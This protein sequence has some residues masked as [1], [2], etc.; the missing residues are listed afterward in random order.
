MIQ[1]TVINPQSA[2]AGHPMTARF[3]AAAGTIGRATTN[4]LVLDDPGRT[5]SRLHA[6]VLYRDGCYFIIDRGG[7]PLLINDQMLGAGN[8]AP[9]NDGDR[10]MIG[11][12]ELT[13]QALPDTAPPPVADRPTQ[14]VTPVGGDPPAHEDP[15][16]DLMA[17][18][19]PAPATPT[20]PAMPMSTPAPE[21]MPSD[22]FA[23]PL[24]PPPSAAP[25]VAPPTKGRGALDDFSDLTTP[26]GEDTPN[27]DSLFGGGLSSGAGGDPLANSPLA[28]PLYRPNTA[29]A[30]DP[31]AALV[32]GAAPPTPAPRSDH[33]PIE[34]F[35]YRPPQA[36]EQTPAATSAPA[37]TPAAAAVPAAPPVAALKPVAPATPP[38]SQPAPRA[39]DDVLLAALLRGLR[40]DTLQPPKALT[41]ELMER[42]GVLLRDAVDGTLQLLL[43]RQEI[44]RELRAEMTMITPQANNPLKFSPDVEVAL[45]HLLGPSVRGFMPADEAMRDAFDDLR[46]HQFGVMVGMRAALT[47]LIARFAPGE[48]ENKIVAKSSLDNLFATRRKARLWDQFVQL[49]ASIA[50]E[51]E[52]DFHSVFGQAFVHAY[53][54]QM[55]RLK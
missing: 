27:I 24:A 25:R 35:G 16:A 54:E 1:I 34:Q 37:P 43:T 7:N 2:S 46:A 5:V 39:G 52:D 30:A 9:L 40:G 15:F 38:P 50:A 51:A 31:L 45:A 8:E 26:V 20:K 10:L 18:L 41:P 12:F 3:D 28:N 42:I 36:V 44:K 33:V 19:E 53:E 11:G 29:G 17:G 22:P 4:T 47:H 21:S 6:Q 13:V 49:Y 55:A 32:G 14:P 23:D 48:L